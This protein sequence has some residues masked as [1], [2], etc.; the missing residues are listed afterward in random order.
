[1][2]FCSFK[3]QAQEFKPVDNDMIYQLTYGLKGVG[4]S[5]PWAAISLHD[6]DKIGENKNVILFKSHKDT[7]IY[8]GFTIDQ[9]NNVSALT[10]IIPRSYAV[11]VVTF[12]ADLKFKLLKTTHMPDFIECDGE[13]NTIFWNEAYK[14]GTMMLIMKKK[15][16]K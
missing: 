1:M 11:T 8:I 6:F 9:N 13:E 4:S 16:A 5:A 15:D 14:P 12:L 7:T 3:I 10:L 2:A